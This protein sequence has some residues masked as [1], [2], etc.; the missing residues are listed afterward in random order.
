MKKIYSIT[1][2]RKKYDVIYN[3]KNRLASLD[4]IPSNSELKKY[5][6]SFHGELEE[7]ENPERELKRLCEIEKYKNGGKLLDIG[8]GRGFFL[9]TVKKSG[10]WKAEG[11]EIS[12][13]GAK[14][15]K[16][17]FGVK[18]HIGTLTTVKF[19][20]ASFDVITMHSTL[21]HLPNPQKQIKIVSKL[22]KPGGLFVFNVPNLYSF[23]Y[24]LAH[25]IGFTY[26]PFMIEHLTYFT[27]PGIITL[28]NSAGLVP[29]KMTSHHHSPF[30][31]LSR[32]PF[33][34]TSTVAKYF[35]EGTDFGGKLCLGNVIYVYAKKSI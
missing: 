8:S 34:F 30:E 31:K 17:N 32:H 12:K 35:L 11:L 21:E 24:R 3:N 2:N 26:N 23:E 16:K 6:E 5:Y 1:Y 7:H 19:K 13:T 29:E 9:N 10:N 4:P 25:L 28:L 27:K 22:L 14:Y 15:A 33:W 18:T 20:P